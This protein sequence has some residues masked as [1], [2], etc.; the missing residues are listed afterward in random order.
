MSIDRDDPAWP[1]EQVV[2]GLL[3]AIKA[4]TLAAGAKLPPERVLAEEYGVARV[5]VGRALDELTKRGV[6]ETRPR[7]GTYVTQ[8]G[9]GTEADASE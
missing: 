3:A 2:A 5:T 1:Y 4:G 7:R 8:A 9:Q 6:I